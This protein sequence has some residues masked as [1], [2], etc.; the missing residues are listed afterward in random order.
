MWFI[1]IADKMKHSQ[2]G[3]MAKDVCGVG[4]ARNR[5]TCLTPY[6]C[7]QAFH[8]GEGDDYDQ[9]IFIR[10]NYTKSGDLNL[11]II[12]LKNSLPRFQY[13]W[14][15]LPLC[16]PVMEYNDCTRM[17]LQVQSIFINKLLPICRK[18]IKFHRWMNLRLMIDY[19]KMS[20]F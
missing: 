6:Q 11:L 7:N 19:R 12:G 20:C 9:V 18:V 3:P 1:A 2:F 8:Y 14:G 17:H 15:L 5:A 10:L 4:S 16:G 13:L